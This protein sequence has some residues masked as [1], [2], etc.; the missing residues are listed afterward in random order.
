M[1]HTPL[2]EYEQWPNNPLDAARKAFTWLTA[3]D[4]PVAV[5]GRLFDH[6]PDR[7][8]AVDELRDLLLRRECPRRVWDQV[9][10]HVIN[11]VRAEGATWTVV[12]VG[13]ALP[14][15]TPMAARLT[16][17]YAD[18]PTDVHAEILR[19]FLEG[20]GSVDLS[21]GGITIRLRW[22][23]Y[24]A[25]HRALVTAMDEPAPTEPER[26]SGTPS[27]SSG[28]P[29]LV[30]ARAVAAG[31]LTA[32][33]A[34]L[35]GTTRLD[36]TA[37]SDWPTAP[38]ESYDALRKARRRAEHRLAAWLAETVDGDEVDDPTTR[39][40]TTR[41]ASPTTG[42]SSIRSRNVAQEAT[43]AVSDQPPETGLQGCG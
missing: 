1:A 40:T 7:E 10:S 3:G 28:H 2:T 19:G 33:E 4:Y 39:T 9:W 36:G 11:R 14:M 34:E 26:L 15:L 43:G 37:L 23:A 32:I 24:R 17:R 22:A 38:G 18:D 42:R 35:I 31:V 25:G 12:A 30:L 27:S 5:D 16:R 20:I 6:L 21:R 41:L 13:L 29:D 8:V